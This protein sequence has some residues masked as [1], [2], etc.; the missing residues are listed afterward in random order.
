M[1]IWPRNKNE[2]TPQG[3]DW[4]NIPEHIAII[5]DGNGRWA[6]K[7]GM[8]RGIGHRAGLEALKAVVRCCD[9]IGV[10][11]L[12][13]YA[14]STENWKRPQSEIGILMSLL[15]E[16]L[17][18][19]LMELV[20]NHV[21]IRVSG[22]IEQLPKD[23]YED[24]LQACQKT[25]NNDGLVFNL[26]LNYGG[27]SEIVKAVREIAQEV[28]NGEI[29]VQ[30]INEK[31]IEDH[32]YTASIPDPELLIRTSGEMRL[33]NFLLWQV[34]YSEIVVAEEYWPDFKEKSLLNAIE[35]YQNR[36][37]RFGG[38]MKVEE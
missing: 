2:H 22:E 29:S 7:K 19:E 37:R 15:K 32:L 23:V 24:V 20:A 1:K 36:E 31:I 33:S 25:K 6:Q 30:E 13:V 5:M 28:R 12:T 11:Y 26:A 9:E 38:I 4:D 27:R 14:F 35:I 34:A 17:K 21:Q 8:P 10:K 3:I 16:Y 18:R